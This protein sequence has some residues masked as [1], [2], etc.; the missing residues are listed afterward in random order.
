MAPKTHNF[1]VRAYINRICVEKLFGFYSYDL[2]LD[3][4][5]IADFS[6]LI[7]IYGDNGSGKTTLLKLI[8]NLLSTVPRQGHKSFI[9]GI[10]FKSLS[11][12]L[13]DSTTVIAER[14]NGN[15]VGTFSMSLI[16]KNKVIRECQFEADERNVIP[17][18]SKGEAEQDRFLKHLS[19]L[20]LSLYFLGDDRKVLSNVYS[21]AEE[22]NEIISPE[23][24]VDTYGLK[25]YMTTRMVDESEGLAID[26][27]VDR[28]VQWI[29]QQALK[30][31]NL[32]EATSNTIYTE[33]IK[34]IARPVTTKERDLDYSADVLI[35]TLL[36]QA[37]R[38]EA[39]ASYGLTSSLSVD[40]LVQA[41]RTAEPSKLRI[42]RSV[43]KPYIDGIK[44]RL[45]A[46]EMIQDSVAT[47]VENINSFFTNKRVRFHLTKGLTIFTSD[48][49]PL[50]PNLLSSGEKQ[51]LLLFCNILTAQ[52]QESIFII[53]E[54][55]LSLNVKWQRR[56]VQALLDCI[57][58]GRMQFLMA[59]HSLELLSLHRH[60]VI[61][62][63]PVKDTQFTEKQAS[64]MQPSLA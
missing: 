21:E 43:L 60:N 54:P 24:F 55:E 57:K 31:S 29:R 48:N 15:I 40:D 49:E 17:V 7:I 39:F 62:L 42:M 16:R 35:K 36:V 8:F 2:R 47:F 64:D 52:D 61:R 32:G 45:D 18:H 9:A 53:D 14:L 12:Q 11:V 41:L 38:N 19:S 6:K 37:K 59:T 10:R 13:A 63:E 25:G 26:K 23:Y 3:Q 22:E 34:R 1:P 56:L 50:N 58:G 33:I 20:N 51:L 4:D 5:S 46:L 28:L 27:A 30:G 44:A